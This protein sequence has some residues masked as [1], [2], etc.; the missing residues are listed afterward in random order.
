LKMEG[1]ERGRRKE[2]RIE[3]GGERRRYIRRK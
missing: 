2:S 1:G 3:K